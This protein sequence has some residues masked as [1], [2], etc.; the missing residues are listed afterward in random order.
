[1]KH[2][3]SASYWKAHTN[4]LSEAQDLKV[5]SPAL[6]SLQ[7]NYITNASLLLHGMATR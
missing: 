6:N 5:Y 7:Q 2:K 4:Y 3:E 1:M